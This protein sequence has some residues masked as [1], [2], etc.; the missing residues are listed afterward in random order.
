MI[1][2]TDFKMNVKTREEIENTPQVA[3]RDAYGEALTELGAKYPNMIVLDADLSE[4]TRTIKFQKKFAERHFNVGI[5]EANMMGIASGLARSGKIVFASSFAMFATGRCWEQIRNSIAH[6]SVNV[7]IA[8]THAG[9]SV[10]PD[11]SS[12]QSLEDIAIT[13]CIPNMMVFVPAD[14]VEA[15]KCLEAAAKINGPVYIRLGRAKTPV[16]L[17]ESYEF[18]PGKGV[19]LKEGNDV[20]LIACGN[21]VYHAYLAAFELEKEGI[22][23]RV[24]NM[25]SIKPIDKELIISAARETAGIVTCEE[26]SV[27]GG[28][29]SAV[30]EVVSENHP[31]KIHRVGVE[32]KFGQSGEPD[33]LFAHYCLT[34]ENIIKQAKEILKK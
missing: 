9:V 18:V 32:N 23:A 25:G 12:H 3:T 30:S 15:K 21:L 34:K 19:I 31:C 10:G 5:A 22:S 28:L 27:T 14:G 4:S 20:S 7:K 24:I 11:G 33:E 17:N 16:F 13:R 1:V 2:R 8:A 29:G 26:H 6:D